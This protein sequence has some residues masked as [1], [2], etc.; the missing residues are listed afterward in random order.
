VLG[1]AE[2]DF[3]GDAR[4]YAFIA[5]EDLPDRREDS[6]LGILRLKLDTIFSDELE[7]ELHGVVQASS[8]P[9]FVGA[10]TVT[11]G[12][13][14]Y[15]D[16]ETT[17][18]E[19][20]DL[21]VTA[22]FDRLNLRWERPGFRLVAGRQ[23]ITWGVTYFWPVLDLFAPFAP[24]RIDRDYKPGVDA[25]R[26]T[27]PIGDFSELEIVAAGQGKDVSD[28]FSGAGL[29]RINVG[30]SDIGFMAGSFHTDTVL[31]TFITTDIKGTG[32]RAEMAYTSSGDPSDAAIDR[33]EFVRATVGVDRQLSATLNL[34]AEAA[35]N[36][37]GADDPQGYLRIARSDRFLRGEVSSLGQRY[38]GLSLGWQLHPL[39]T[40]SAAVIGNLGDNSALFQPT[41]SWWVSES[42]TALF[43][44][45]VG[46]GDGLDSEGR[47]QS[48]YGATP[49]TVW[50]AIQGYF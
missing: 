1:A 44:F 11:G 2:I 36:G 22:E 32:L 50:A 35:W 4:L 26:A 33:D 13:R 15:F 43:G 18:V 19:N 9:L 28:D 10:S 3:D 29:A 39:V 42:V 46:V 14:R 45:F 30:L 7:L 12:T 49:T 20:D 31:G 23:A 38:A 27:V 6:E 34:T 5:L 8:P 24:Q 40:A 47:P 21:L 17:L 37:Y 41:V 25:V 16:L 48:E